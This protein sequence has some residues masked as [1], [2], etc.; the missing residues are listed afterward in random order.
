MC[1]QHQRDSAL[2]WLETVLRARLSVA[3]NF[4]RQRFD[5]LA[6]QM[7]KDVGADFPGADKGFGIPG[8]GDPHRYLF[9]YG[10]GID[11]YADLFTKAVEPRHLFTRPQFFER[12]DL[13]VH[14]SL[15]RRISLREEDEIVDVPSRAE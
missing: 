7:R 5:I 12:L 15:A 8:R 10:S 3:L 6:D 4:C 13:L 11:A 2:L 14:D 9:L 1:M